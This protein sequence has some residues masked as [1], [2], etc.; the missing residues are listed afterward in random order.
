M[1]DWAGIKHSVNSNLAVPLDTT[2]GQR[3][4][5]AATAVNA[6]NTAMAI[7][8]GIQGSLAAIAASH[9]AQFTANG[10]FA[11]PA[12][13]IYITAISAG[14]N[15]GNGYGNS[16]GG[17]GSCGN[18]VIHA[19]FYIASAQNIAVTVGP[20]D[21]VIGNLLTLLKGTN[22]GNATSAAVGIGGVNLMASSAFG[23]GG[24]GGSQ[25]SGIAGNGQPGIQGASLDGISLYGSPGGPNSLGAYNYGSSGGGGG[26]PIIFIKPGTDGSGGACTQFGTAAGN[27]GNSYGAGGAGGPGLSSGNAPGGAGG[28][29]YMLIEW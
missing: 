18:F 17:G 21:T 1:S 2:L 15:G 28:L 27:A 16:A 12:G 25:T 8:K 9:S 24:N 14:G 6:T 19:P 20:G 23:K 5:A 26:V 7:L 3:G 11:A 10:T 22:G 29:G 4:D 13:V